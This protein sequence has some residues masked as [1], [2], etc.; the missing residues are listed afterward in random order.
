MFY[1][2]NEELTE[3]EAL[4]FIQEASINDETNR[5]FREQLHDPIIAV[6]ET[7]RG[8]N[9]YIKLGTEFLEAN[10]EMLS[11][12]YPTKAVIFPRT[13]VDKVF[14]LFGFEIKEFKQILRELMKQV[15]EKS[16]FQIIMAS[17]TNVIH[18]LVLYYS[19]MINHRQLR[20]SARQQLG[21]SVY[22]NRFNT[23]F[24]PPHPNEAV[25]GY[26]YTTLDNSWG[27]VK[28]EN[29]INWIS[30]MTETAYAFYRTKLLTNMSMKIL[31]DFI[32]RVRTSIAQSLRLLANRYFDE[33]NNGEGNMIGTDVDGNADYVMTKNTIRLVDNLMRKIKEGDALYTEN[34][35]TYAGI[36][37]LK[38]VK[39]E[40]LYTLAQKMEHADIRM[41]MNAILYV[42]LSKEEHTIEDINS[43]KYIS[44]ITNFPTAIDRAIEGKPII[45]PL[46]KKY[47]TDASI[48]KAYICFVATYILARMNDVT[49]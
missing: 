14:E 19:D 36:A 39:T 34:N 31:S 32:Y 26:V 2:N 11:K 44:R 9:A 3:A 40:S 24:P 42:F 29:V 27:L 41:I 46:S 13:Y 4:D 30:G 6:L 12:E 7:P 8:R 33:L 20:D 48:V 18:S 38:N 10:M 17:P 15:N 1:L 5:V 23:S 35:E 16:S 22:N 28:S 25:M 21:L 43:S 47:K 45:L 49:K 37:R